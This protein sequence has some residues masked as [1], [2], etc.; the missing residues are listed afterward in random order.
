MKNFL[1]PTNLCSRGAKIL[2]LLIFCVLFFELILQITS[3]HITAIDRVTTPPT[4]VRP[5]I[6]DPILGH[7]GNPEFREHD[8]NGFRNQIIPTE[9]YFVALGDSH[10][11]GTSVEREEAW[12]SVLSHLLNKT[13]YNM[14]LPGY[15]TTQNLHNIHQ[16]L[17]LKPQLIIFGSYFGNDFYDS[18][19]HSQR[20]GTLKAQVSESALKKIQYLESQNPIRERVTFGCRLGKTTKDMSSGR[21]FLSQTS[22]LYGMLR[23]AKRILRN[24]L[25]PAQSTFSKNFE[26]AVKSLTPSQLQFCSVFQENDWKTIFT[27]SYRNLVLND[28]DLRIRTGVEL[29]K[30]AIQRMDAVARRNETGFLVALLPT[31]ETVFAPKVSDWKPHNELINLISNEARLKNEMV[32]FFQDQGIKFIDLAPPLRNATTQPYFESADGHPNSIGQR[33]IAIELARYI[34]ESMNGDTIKD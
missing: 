34:Q 15:G 13:G 10:T 6:D 33:I 29:S 23:T 2:G 19:S 30:Q 28:S 12:P 17:A 9:A 24:A 22:K 20:N 7:R 5:E 31:K 4:L 27:A 18:F 25:Y 14:G 32:Q 8:K 21:K 3:A 16:A 26:T 11:Y 1:L